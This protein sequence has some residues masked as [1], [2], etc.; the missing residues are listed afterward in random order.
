MTLRAKD[1]MCR[2]VVYVYVHT[3]VRELARLLIDKHISGVPVL[4]ETDNLVGV[5]SQ[6]DI[7][8][9]HLSIGQEVITEADFYKRPFLDEISFSKGFHIEDFN[10]ATVQEIM[11][12]VLTTATENTPVHELAALMH[13]KRIHRVIITRGK[14]LRGIVTTMDLIALLAKTPEQAVQ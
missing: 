2:D 9:Y 1:I 6:T 12:P 8:N 7:V 11:T 14:K 5:V 10:A 3:D 13:E 4:D